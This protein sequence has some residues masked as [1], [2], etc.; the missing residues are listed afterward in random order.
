MS[1]NDELRIL[2]YEVRWDDHGGSSLRKHYIHI[3]DYQF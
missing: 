1:F 3:S 2:N